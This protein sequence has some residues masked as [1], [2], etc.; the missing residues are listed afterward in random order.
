[1]MELAVSRATESGVSDNNFASEQGNRVAIVSKRPVEFK[2]RLDSDFTLIVKHNAFFT[3]LLPE[4][5]N[6]YPVYAIIRNP[7]AVLG[8]WN[9]LDLPVTRGEVRASQWLAPDLQQALDQFDNLYDKQIYIL[10]WYLEKYAKLDTNQV[11]KYE[12][13][14]AS[15]GAEL[16]KIDQIAVNFDQQLESR[17]KNKLYNSDIMKTLGEKLLSQDHPCWTFYS[18]EEA[19][20]LIDW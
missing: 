4:L 14:I 2:K 9:S 19:E 13:I 17:N 18:R 1:M 16:N 15:N 3:I 20:Q 6:H 11:L 8:S 7:I 10:G 12:D 5:V